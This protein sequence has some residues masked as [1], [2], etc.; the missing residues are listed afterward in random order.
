MNELGKGFFDKTKIIWYIWEV[1]NTI[2]T[3][4]KI[5]LQQAKKSK[6]KYFMG[7]KQGCKWVSFEN[8]KKIWAFPLAS[9]NFHG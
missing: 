4:K 2:Q 7:Q 9:I 8:K 5:I 1:Q 6:I 3:L